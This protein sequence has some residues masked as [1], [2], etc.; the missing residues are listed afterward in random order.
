MS[1]YEYSCQEFETAFKKI[2]KISLKSKDFSPVINPKAYI[3]G[4][5]PGA[6]KSI[7]NNYIQKINKSNVII[8]NGDEYRKFHPYFTEIVEK[9]NIDFPKYTSN[10]SSQVTEK[11]IDVLSD[12]K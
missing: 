9:Y 4:G 12:E 8:I 1:E 6:G 3:L 11:L 7:L 2:L 5:Q 10:F